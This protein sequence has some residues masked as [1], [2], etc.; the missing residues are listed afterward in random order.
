M[1]INIAPSSDFLDQIECALLNDLSGLE[2][3]LCNYL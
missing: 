1:L 2:T 3:D